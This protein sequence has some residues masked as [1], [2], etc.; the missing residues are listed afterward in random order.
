MRRLA[1][2]AVFA[3]LLLLLT[4]VAR[5][6]AQDASPVV[7]PFTPDP[8]ECRIA[9]RPPDEILGLI[10]S[11]VAASPTA[12]LTASALT[13]AELPAGTPADEMTAG[14]IVATVREL[15]ACNNAGELA[16]VFALYSDAVLRGALT[17]DPI[18]ALALAIAAPPTG[19]SQAELV[20][21]RDIRVLDDGRVGAVVEVRDSQ[22][23]EIAFLIFARSG[24]RWLVDALTN[25][26]ADGTPTS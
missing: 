18:A 21:V 15:I 9:P 10:A 13:E 12:A 1:P 3:A 24:D 20:D 7:F 16:R 5:T 19:G 8:A 14:E 2:T 11:P 23:T 25:V 17:G 22:R 6:A 26:L 4:G